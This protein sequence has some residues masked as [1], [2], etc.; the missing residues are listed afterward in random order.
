MATVESIKKVKKKRRGGKALKF[1]VSVLG[2]ALLSVVALVLITNNGKLNADGFVRLFNGAGDEAT[3]EEFLFDAGSNKDLADFNGGLAVASSVG[4]QVIDR[5]GQLVFMES[6]DFASPTVYTDGRVGVAYD[7]GGYRLKLFDET[8]V[9]KSITTTGKIISARLNQD[10]W[11]ALCTQENGGYK[12]RATVYNDKGDEEYYWRS[13]TGYTLSAEV[14]PDDKKLAVLTLTEDGSRVVFFSL[15]SEDELSS[16]TLAGTLVT[17]IAYIDG[18]SVLAV[19]EEQLAVIYEDGG[20]DTLYSYSGKYLS[21]YALNSPS[22]TALV[23]SDYLVGNQGSIVT[24][25]PSSKT[26]GT[27]TTDRKVLSISVDGDYLAVLFSD[28][29]VIYDKNLE[30]YASFGDTAGAV[31][32]IMRSDGTALCLTAHSAS[33]KKALTD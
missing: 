23:L 9:I 10:G 21:G 31:G 11:L 24:I 20:S 18:D 32:T 1:F 25:S 27:L 16:A 17:E 4:L 22:F 8:G 30:E 3:A 12:G 33:V 15:D 7:L 6:C 26:L 2:L 14:A 28:G 29:L 13:A 5:S 19:S